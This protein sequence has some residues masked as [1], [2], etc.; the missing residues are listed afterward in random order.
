M[1][2]HRAKGLEFEIVCVADLGRGPRWGSEV[3]RI[4]RDGRFGLRLSEPGTGKALPA[5][6]YA[7]LG[8]ER[9]ERE[10]AEERRIFYVAMTR[11][12]ERLVLSG[13]ARMERLDSE[14]SPMG[15][16][17]PAMTDAG[18]EASVVE[19]SVG[20]VVDLTRQMAEVGRPRP[21][22]AEPPEPPAPVSQLS[23]SSLSEFER[24][25]YRFYVERVLGL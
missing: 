11:A 16:I 7:S 19:A 18:V 10:D 21:G 2:M 22:V 14:R 9:R 12:R 4:G 24:C 3:L 13:A 5:L 15:W 25:G 17:L 20:E 23:Y 1:T 6:D 8:D